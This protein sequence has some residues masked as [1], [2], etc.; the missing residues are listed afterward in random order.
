M[1]NKKNKY[2]VE[3]IKLLI[4]DT[5]NT[6]TKY[7]YINQ[8]KIESLVM[9][10][11]NTY[12][13][14]ADILDIPDSTF[15]IL[16]D[17]LE[18]KYPKSK[19]LDIIGSELPKD[20][21]NK[22]K[23][24]YYLPSMN[25]VKPGSKNLN[26]WIKKYDTGNYVISEKLNGLSSLLII[27]LNE[28]KI[29]AKLYTRGDGNI[30]Q[31]ITHLI[32][33]LKFNNGESLEL[34]DND[35]LI[36][37]Y[38]SLKKYMV[39]NNLESLVIRGELII[40][41]EKF[42]QYADKYPKALSFIAGV[43]NSKAEKFTKQDSRNK[44]KNLD[45]VSYQLIYPEYKAN[46]QFD[47]LKNDIKFKVANNNNYIEE[48][49]QL[50]CEK[51]LLEYKEKSLYEIDGIIITDNS[52]INTNI[53]NVNPKYSVAFKMP[54]EDLQSKETIIEYIE[55]N[56][57]KNGILK[58]RIKYQTIIID[59][60]IF[61]FTTGFNARYIKDNKLGPGSRI[62]IIKSGD[63]IPYIY[64]I[65]STSSN[66]KWSE[67]ITKWHWNDNNV[68]A[69]IDDINDLP[70]NKVLL[71]FFNQFKINYMK[72]GVITRLIDAEFDNINDIL[73]LQTSSLL[74]IEGFQIKSSN[75][76]VLEIKEKILKPKHSIEKLM[77]GSNCFPNF[78]MRKIKNIVNNFKITDIVNNNNITIEK[79]INI[80]GVGDIVANDFI[81]YLPIFIK[82][83]NAHPLLKIDYKT[84]T[85]D[86]T[87]LED[88][89]KNHNIFIIGKKICF[90]GFRDEEL[91]NF[92]ENNGG[93]IVSS[94]SGNTSLV[95]TKDINDTSSKLKKAR[96]KN[97]TIM[98]LID[99][100]NKL[101]I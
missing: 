3:F 101:K 24:P 53:V 99:F 47:I 87:N 20:A 72:E 86:N 64:K 74:S 34:D 82:W 30:G 11:K 68:E 9:D 91:T 45:F 60:D 5:I 44:A 36:S 49:N 62:I 46:E 78:G 1:S 97:I 89:H 35:T 51:I 71:Q 41:K 65:L 39:K 55:Y 12:Y 80:E 90:T 38:K 59:G 37:R 14:N 79:L 7:D 70:M 83:L 28:N 58:P 42:K 17:I 93:S 66:N 92:V 15:D 56:V 22:V 54:F 76:L 16:V 84:N 61:N 8:K 31:D 69:V 100:K 50:L 23:L 57:S 98:S 2:D 10:A 73:N 40:S 32:P 29:N 21:T 81:K 95:I 43:V 77:V 75:K 33:F 85:K 18:E 48:L 19:V 25:K 94:V 13:N 52:K 63:V 88:K 67:P 27:N 96:S 26:I 6:L 4:K